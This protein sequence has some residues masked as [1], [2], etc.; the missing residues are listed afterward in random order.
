M[1]DINWSLALDNDD[2]IA[3]GTIQVID[4]TKLVGVKATGSIEVL[5]Y[6]ALVGVA[7]ASTITITA[8]ASL[9][10]KS[11]TI[12][13]EV[14]TEG[15]DFNAETN[16]NTTATNLAAAIDALADVSA[17]AVGAVVTIT[18][19]AA[20]RAGN[21]ITLSTD[22]TAGYT[23][24]ESHLLGGLDHA[25]ITVGASVLVQGTDFTAETNNN[26]TAT[27]I[28]AAID[29]LVP[30]VSS[31]VT[32][33]V[34]IEAA[35]VGTAGN[36]ALSATW[37]NMTVAA[38]TLSGSTLT[39]GLAEGTVVV[40]AT[41]LTQGS[42][43]DAETSNTVTATNIAAAIDALAGI[44]SA[45]VGALITNTASAAG[46]AGNIVITTN[47]SDA[48][49]IT[50]MSGGADYFYSDALA[51]DDG[52][53]AVTYTVKID[54][55]TPGSAPEVN[56]FIDVSYD[57]DTW[58]QLYKFEKMTVAGE[59]TATVSKDIRLYSR[60]RIEIVDATATVSVNGTTSDF[61][62]E[63]DQSLDVA[64]DVSKSM[65]SIFDVL[66]VIV[67]PI[68]GQALTIPAG[69][70][71]TIKEFQIQAWP[72][73]ASDGGLFAQKGDT[74]LSF[75]TGTCFTTE[76]SPDT[77]DA[78]L[79]NGQYYIDYATGRGRGKKA[80]TAT[81]D[82]VSY[83][84]LALSSVER[85]APDYENATYDMAQVSAPI[86]NLSS[87]DKWAKVVSTAYEESHVLLAEAGV[88]RA[89][90]VE[91]DPSA[92]TDI[93]YVQFFNLTA[94]PA[95]ATAVTFEVPFAINHTT[96]A[97]SA[98]SIDFGLAGMPCSVG[99]VVVL[100]TTAFTKTE[101]G[102]IAAFSAEVFA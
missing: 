78:D 25:T 33:D 49:T 24:P 90:H 61:G 83:K 11:F 18:A 74:S 88:V 53:S 28:A 72:I 99:C 54:S 36:A 2:R 59:K 17:V 64:Q 4:Y 41:T 85:Q 51:H 29:A 68:S 44:A 47:A 1:R 22:A 55:I 97:P 93:Y 84:M 23:M 71:G 9:N 38:L 81:S 15:V 5:D 7:A 48:L 101:T 79:T 62:G 8:F 95:D 75:G 96:G 86:P 87:V 39:G 35:A 21:A 12:G 37:D 32:N 69:A 57:N 63:G 82:T 66:P 26:T 14:L 58:K 3:V 77:D 102:D 56:F 27:N 40:G 20:G 76:V 31:A 98:R 34:S 91:I 52:A 30:F 94:E 67:L 50:A 60:V 43:F 92:A 6:A 100:S 89:V 13:A 19:V 16:N 80:T 70:A 65:Q 73:L 10:D 46:E 42:D 45:A